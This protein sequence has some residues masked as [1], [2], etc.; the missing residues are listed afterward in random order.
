MTLCPTPCLT[1]CPPFY[2]IDPYN[3]TLCALVTIA[4]QT[5][6]FIIAATCKF[7]K[8]TDFAGGSNFVILALLTFFIPRTFGAR[9]IV[10]TVC[11]VLWGIRLSGFLLYRIIKI[12]EDNRFDD[13]RG[14]LLKFAGFWMFQAVWVF[15]VSLPVIFINAGHNNDCSKFGPA[16]IIGTV[17]F[18][19][20]L[21]VEAVADQQKFNF[22][23]NAENKGKFCDT[24]LWRWSRHPNYLG[25]ITLWLGIFIMSA[26]TLTC[27]EWVAVLSPIFITSILLFVSGVPLLEQKADNRYGSQEAY[28]QYR[29]QTSPIVFCPTSLYIAIP[30]RL[31]CLFLCE[32]PF[33]GSGAPSNCEDQPKDV[34][35]EETNIVRT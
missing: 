2:I 35:N 6:F 34:P 18:A 25:E 16:E 9:Q 32:F 20:G 29:K 22:R 23:E 31:K 27:G 3:L 21:L 11:V 19:F 13:I 5:C 17:C 24:G 7:D 8:V 28:K 1:F 4:M 15:T 30:Q 12:G 33:Y 14:N 10:V 26:S